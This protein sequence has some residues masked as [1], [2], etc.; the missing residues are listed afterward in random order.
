VK[1]RKKTN[2][3]HGAKNSTRISF[4]GSTTDL[5]LEGV[6]SMTSEAASARARVARIREEVE[7]RIDEIRILEESGRDVKQKRRGY[8]AYLTAK[9]DSKFE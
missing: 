9:A 2:A 7:A 1:R 3:Y 4:S 6:K 8:Q 5:K